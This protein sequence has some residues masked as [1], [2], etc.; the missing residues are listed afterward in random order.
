M[1]RYTIDPTL[2]LRTAHFIDNLKEMTGEGFPKLERRIRE[3]QYDAFKFP[4]P[5]TETVRDYFRLYLPVAYEPTRKVTSNPWLLAAELEVPGCSYAFFHP[6]FDLLFGLIESSQYWALHFGR[7]P[8][9]WIER[10][11]MRG[12]ENMASEWKQM[13]RNLSDRKHRKR[14]RAQIDT[15]SFTH[16]SMMRLPTQIRDILFERKGLTPGWTRKYSS[17]KAEVAK[18]QS[19]RNI[20][21]LA[22]LL[23]LAHEA[24]EIGDTTRFYQAKIALIENLSVL[25]EKK[26]FRRIS[27]LLKEHIISECNNLSPRRYSRMEFFG[28]GY[29]PSWRANLIHQHNALENQKFISKLQPK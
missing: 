15:L 12:D 27:K 18:I 13:N 6:I 3:N 26:A 14:Q 23:G 24:A 9:K 20:D 4:A 22:A 21:G 7:I 8:Q 29:P 5:A 25:D 1:H 19:I 28:L 2:F 16:L 10:V 17:T 11:E